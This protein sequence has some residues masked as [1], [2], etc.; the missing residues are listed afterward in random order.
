MA[1]RTNFD[2]AEPAACLVQEVNQRVRAGMVFASNLLQSSTQIRDT[3]AFLHRLREHAH[4]I[5]I[6]QRFSM[7]LLTGGIGLCLYVGGN[8]FWMYHHQRQ[9]MQ[10]WQSQNSLTP[11]SSPAPASKL[12]RLVI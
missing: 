11:L 8:Y 4:T 7:L 1:D 12:T 3:R 5:G 9:L 2:S 10:E 6:R